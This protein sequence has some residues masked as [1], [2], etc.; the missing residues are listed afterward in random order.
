ML[1]ERGAQARLLI[2]ATTR[3]EFHAPW[4]TRS[5]HLVIAL[6]PLDRAQIARMVAAI[7]ERHAL[8]KDVVE[9]LSDRTGGVPL[10]IEELTRL[11][12]EGGAQ[13]IPPTLQQSLAARL[14]RLGEAR[15]VAQI[16]AVLGR[17]FTYE[18]LAAVAGRPDAGLDAA[19]DVLADADLLFVEGVAPACTYR[20]KHAL[21]Q[22]AAYESL[23]K[24]RRQTL[25]R[26]AAEA[27]VAAPDPQPEL[28]AYHFTQA[29]LTEFAI[30]WW[31][32]AGDAA[33]S[34]SAFQEAI[35]HLGKAIEIADK[36]NREGGSA[37]TGSDVN[38]GIR[39]KYA[40]AVGITEGYASDATQEAYRRV[41]GERERPSQAAERWPALY[42]QWFKSL[43]RGDIGAALATAQ[44]QLREGERARL[45]AMVAWALRQISINLAQF[46]RFGEARRYAERARELYD[47][48]W[49]AEAR[50]VTGLDFLAVSEI[51]LAWVIWPT[52]DIDAA[53]AHLEAAIARAEAIDPAYTLVSVLGQ[54]LYVLDL[55]R[56]PAETLKLADRAIALATEKGIG[57]HLVPNRLYRSWAHGRLHDPRIGVSDLG[58]ALNDLHESGN[59]VFGRI[60]LAL[61]ADLQAASGAADDALATVAEGLRV[62][63]DAGLES[64]LAH[65]LTLRGELLLARDPTA[66]EAAFR[67]AIVVAR[68]QGARTFEL[69]AA[70]PLARLLWAAN[71][72]LEAHAVLAPALEGFTPTPE[73]PAIAEAQA[74]LAEFEESEA[75]RREQRNRGIRAKY[76][77]AVMIT[78]GYTSDATE[79][80][81]RRIGGEG[82]RP[83]QAAERWPVL[84]S[85]WLKSAM[86]GDIGAALAAAQT[87][88]REGEQARLPGMA[89]WALRLISNSLANSGRF[90]EARRHAERARELYDVSWAAE[91]RA[92]TDWTFWPSPRSHLPT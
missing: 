9:G 68:E 91:A 1:A 38:R 44:T 63:A 65:L 87:Q 73:L 47:V 49:A 13:T 56:R 64:E 17:E 34:R 58:A 28:V 31:G 18:L 15:E 59:G 5:H 4:T 6:A 2:V 67:E 14:D 35:S 8:A 62:S 26:R 82:E 52:G 89:A 43:L 12:L 88:L 22:D 46:G 19:L 83:S 84:Y 66:A 45:P 61:L 39:A 48:S 90:A 92:V 54:A 86:R 75:V 41:G 81:Y 51:T 79:A 21:I 80:A 78:E 10:F 74:L 85:Q 7:A 36:D 40:Q 27:L 33:L 20:F 72:P 77:Q 71:R 70:L 32:K 30:E 42:S 76:A 23:L 24:T 16:G 3:P 29:G 55:A 57:S 60:V 37:P 11:L 53:Y 50:A 69:L 25:H